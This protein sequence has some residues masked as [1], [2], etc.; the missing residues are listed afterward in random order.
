MYKSYT[1]NNTHYEKPKSS[2]GEWVTSVA[3]VLRMVTNFR[4]VFS[5]CKSATDEYSCGLVSLI[6]LPENVN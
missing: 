4:M 3:Y 6:Q 2:R 5:L 1:V